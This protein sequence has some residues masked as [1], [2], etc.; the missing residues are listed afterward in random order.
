MPILIMDDFEHTFMLDYSLKR[1]DYIEAF[2][3]KIGLKAVETR[4][5]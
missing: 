3:E 5:K 2:F 1:A 4:L